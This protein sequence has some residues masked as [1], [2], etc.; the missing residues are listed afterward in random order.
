MLNKT[1]TFIIPKFCAIIPKTDIQRAI[2]PQQKPLMKPET[3]L[4]YSGSVFCAQT[5]AI[6]CESI[7]VK[8]IMENIIIE[9]IECSRYVNPNNSII[10]KVAHIEKYITGF[11][12]KSFSNCGL[13]NE[14]IAP[15][16]T[17]KN[18]AKPI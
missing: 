17:N 16:K 8:P 18:S 13:I 7:V 14:A 4:L 1:S 9:I 12:P 5:T 6:G 10:G 15:A 3:I 11:A 2:I